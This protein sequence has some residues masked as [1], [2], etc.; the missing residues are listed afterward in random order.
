VE[1]LP[2][3]P[4]ANAHALPWVLMACDN[5]SV[6]IWDVEHATAGV[7][8]PARY[9]PSPTREGVHEPPPKPGMAAELR[10]HGS[11][12]ACATVVG[13]LPPNPAQR[14]QT[15]SQVSR[16]TAGGAGGQLLWLCV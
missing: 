2:A 11:W 7:V 3:L 12:V 1:F 10:G 4:G 8:S 15:T 6:Y 16:R 5:G 14:A 9:S 13:P